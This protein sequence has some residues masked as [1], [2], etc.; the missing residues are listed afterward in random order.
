MNGIQLGR[1]YPGAGYRALQRV[2]LDLHNRGILLAIC[3]KNNEEEALAAL[4]HPE[5]LL[6]P[7]HFAA[8]Y[9]NWNAK[10]ENL[11]HIA[12]ELNVGLDSLVFV[13]DNPA[14][15]QSI[16]LA[17]PEVT[18]IDLPSD[19]MGYAKAVRE[20]PL[21]ERVTSSAE[22][23]ERSRYYVEQRQRRDVGKQMSSLEDFYRSLEQKVEIAPLSKDNLSRIAELIK[24]TNQ[25]NLTTMRHSEA[26]IAAFGDD[27][28]YDV[29]AVKVADRFGDNGL[30]GVCVTR[31][32]GDASEIETFLLS[33]RVIGRTVETAIL[34]FLAEEARA[35]GLRRLDGWF[36]PTRK[37]KPAE[38]V[39]PAHN[40]ELREQTDAG[41]QW[42]LD[43]SRAT[44][45]CPPWIQ[46]VAHCQAARA[47]Q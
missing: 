21:F 12:N 25:F 47:A 23:R 11:Q 37:N 15:R 39:Y 17:L 32:A 22:D 43:L 35:R 9:A 38:S 4:N 33:C 24:K 41:S 2:L 20:C 28:N 6:R 42:A 29:Y 14:E 13:D 19:P 34:A 5:M 1:E 40:F 31:R 7:E 45:E 36:R 8:I 18:V 44:V 27:P 16:R 10:H 3:S 26:Q 30:V 46:L